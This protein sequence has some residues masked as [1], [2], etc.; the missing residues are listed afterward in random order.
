VSG[1][2]TRRDLAR[3]FTRLLFLQ[4][5]VHR[6]GM[7]NIGL[8]HALDAAAP[9]L[10]RNGTSLLARHAEYFNTNPHMA[11]LVVG[12]VLRIEEEVESTG[13]ASVSRFK[14]AAAS[15]LAAAGDVFFS[16]ALKPLA[17]TLA[18]LSAIYNFFPGLVGILILYNAAVFYCRYRG[19]T[20]GYARGWGLVEVFSR[21]SVQRLLGIARG[22]AA[23][24]GG[25]LAGAILSRARTDGTTTVAMLL[26]VTGLAWLA[27]RR[28]ITAPR[29]A[30]ILFP[31][32]WIVA[33]V[34][35]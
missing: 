33:M 26:G 29:A 16:G 3:V 22:V 13:P 30:V 12:G 34:L 32:S 21:P 7:Q 5:T 27:S 8:M 18:C 17:L 9:R 35:K 31:V 10:S 11:P 24:A 25:L 14:Q 2:L 28:G 15:A 23:F 20:L 19:I 4:A 6:R 1:Q